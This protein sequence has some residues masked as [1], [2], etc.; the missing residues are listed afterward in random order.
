MY[1]SVLNKLQYNIDPVVC[2]RINSSNAPESASEEI[3]V[4]GTS[5]LVR[6]HLNHGYYFRVIELLAPSNV[7]VPIIPEL[8]EM[9]ITPLYYS[10]TIYSIDSFSRMLFRFGIKL[11]IP[12]LLRFPDFLYC[13][14]LLLRAVVDTSIDVKLSDI[15]NSLSVHII[16][17]GRW[18][19][20]SMPYIATILR[21]LFGIFPELRRGLQTH[22]I[23][24][25]NLLGTYKLVYNMVCSYL[26][27]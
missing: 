15:T 8:S 23:D 10:A 11:P 22:D 27:C 17:T 4:F 9:Q 16:E 19:N 7:C 6:K 21:K 13:D 20:R 25:K 3:I 18:V 1:R 12:W 26:N 14:G 24:N 5:I 2:Q